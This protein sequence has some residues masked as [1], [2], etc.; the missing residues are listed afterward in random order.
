MRFSNASLGIIGS[1]KG[2]VL[3]TV[4]QERPRKINASATSGNLHNNKEEMKRKLVLDAVAQYNYLTGYDFSGSDTLQRQVR[5]RSINYQILSYH[6]DYSG[7]EK[8]YDIK[9]ET[10]KDSKGKNRYYV[11]AKDK[12]TQQIKSAKR[13]TNKQE[14]W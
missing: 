6:F 2:V 14:E 3:V 13:W 4:G 11:V 12:K 9:R 10:R 1:I 8:F 5:N 7:V